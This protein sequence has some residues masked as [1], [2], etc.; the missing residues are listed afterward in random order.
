MSENLYMDTMAYSG[1]EKPWHL[2]GTQFAEDFTSEEAIE[3]AKL[4]FHV[5]T[6]QLGLIADGRP[7]DYFATVNGDTNE[8]LGVVGSRYTPLQNKQAFG[9]FDELLAETGARYTTAGAIGKGEKIWLLAKMPGTFEPLLGDRIE[10]FCL[11]VNSHD[12]SYPITVRFT[13][14]RVVCQNT[15]HM[16]LHD[17]TATVSLKHTSGASSRLQQAAM[18]LKEKNRYFASL[19][20]TFK[21]LAS[22]K[23]DDEWIQDYEDL[24]FG[25]ISKEVEISER[26]R[27]NR[28][29][30]RTGFEIY[31]NHGKGLEIPGVKGT[32]WGAYNAAIEYVDYGLAGDDNDPKSLLFGG[33]SDFKQEAFDHAY[34]LVSK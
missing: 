20:E 18:I 30:K 2:K 31:L 22:F 15:L 8:I 27:N 16:A 5:A 10:E 1:E 13:P 7:V 3:A 12:G 26:V 33:L 29:Q 25:K 17:S 6:K 11:L 32:A 21:E 28:I 34:A 19:G 4:G 23:I 9:F 14:I 24:L